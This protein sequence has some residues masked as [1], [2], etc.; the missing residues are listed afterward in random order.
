M[1]GRF[2]LTV[3][4]NQVKKTFS[5]TDCLDFSPQYNIAPTHSICAIASSL[6]HSWE[7]RFFHWGL[8]PSWAKNSKNASNLI[9]ARLETLGDKP[10]FKQAFSQR[11]CLIIADG[12]YE[13]NRQLYGK[14]P[15]FFHKEDKQI[16]AFAGLWEK[17]QSPDGKI[18]E[19]ATI[20]NTQARGVMATIHPRM[21]I[22]LAKSAYKIWLDNSIQNHQQLSD[23]LNTHLE[24]QLCYYPVSESVN[25]VKNNYPELLKPQVVKLSQQLSLF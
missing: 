17:W 10:S 16:F 24:S 1:C 13:W 8:I 4:P 19:S 18:I 25:Y 15:L 3:T 9:N 2:T 7:T 21:P 5:L 6:N 11:R 20:I 12:F 22:I 14:N 23:L